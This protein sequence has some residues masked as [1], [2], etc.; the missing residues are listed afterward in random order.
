MCQNCQSLRFPNENFP[1]QLSYSVT[2]NKAQGQVFDKV[3]IYLTKPAL[4][5]G[6][7]Y[8]TFSRVTAVD[9]HQSDKRG[10][11]QGKVVTKNIVC[12]ELQKNLR[13]FQNLLFLYY[14]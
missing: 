7:L 2:I 8:G 11:V 12:G 6:Q 3:G 13:D 1:L 9:V 14:S 10:E 5:Y 4:S